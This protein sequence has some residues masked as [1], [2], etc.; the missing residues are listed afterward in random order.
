M[1]TNLYEDNMILNSIINARCY[2]NESI[3]KEVDIES[4]INSI[5]WMNHDVDRFFQKYINP[6]HIHVIS[7]I[8][9][10]SNDNIRP[11][12][13]NV[14]YNGAEIMAFLLYN[15]ITSIDKSRFMFVKINSNSDC[16]SITNLD[17]TDILRLEFNPI[18]NLHDRFTQYADLVERVI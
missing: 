18:D 6:Y 12:L 15:R 5:D 3:T 8:V 14:N 4:E 7:F 13:T 10:S 17:F 16:D 2:T 11:H 1:S 9:L